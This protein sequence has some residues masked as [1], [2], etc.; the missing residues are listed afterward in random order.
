GGAADNPGPVL[1]RRRGEEI[2]DRAGAVGLAQLHLVALVASDEVEVLGQRDHLG[3]GGDRSRDQPPRRLQVGVQL[4]PRNHL[5]RR[6]PR[7]H[8]AALSLAGS[9]TESLV[10]LGSLQ[11]PVTEKSCAKIWPSGFLSTRCAIAA[12][13][14]ATG[15]TMPI[16]VEAESPSPG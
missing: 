6:D 3:A 13:T 9:A 7:R 16:T 5:D 8:G 2:L 4:G 11:L 14:P 10:T 15:L 1:A 12:V